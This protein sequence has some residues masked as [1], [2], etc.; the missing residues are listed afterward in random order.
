[1]PEVSAMNIR[2]LKPSEVSLHRSVRLRALQDTPTSFAESH[3]EVACRPTEYWETFTQSVTAPGRHVMFLCQ[4]ADAIHGCVYGALARDRD[5][6]I[7][8]GGMWVDPTQRGKGIGTALMKAVLAWGQERQ[9]D[10]FG[11]WVPTHQPAAIALYARLGF[12]ETGAV[13]PLPGQEEL[14]IMAMERGA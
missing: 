8:V 14:S 3:A 6:G 7:R 10:H 9:R 12:V 13:R 11:L 1:M 4:A 2:K 5:D